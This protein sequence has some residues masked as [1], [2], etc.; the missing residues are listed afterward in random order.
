MS[1]KAVCATIQTAT[2]KKVKNEADRVKRSFSFMVN[3]L[4][5]EAIESRESKNKSKLNKPLSTKPAISKVGE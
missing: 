3:E 2:I 1:T 5:L 4:L